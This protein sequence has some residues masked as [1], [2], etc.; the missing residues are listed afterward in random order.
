MGRSLVPANWR[1]CK[2]LRARPVFLPVHRGR[3]V[4]P[5]RGADRGPQQGRYD[6]GTGC[7]G[8]GDDADR[9]CTAGERGRTMPST[10][11]PERFAKATGTKLRI[12]FEPGKPAPAHRRRPAKLHS[13]RS[14]RT[15]HGGKSLPGRSCSNVPKPTRRLPLTDRA[16]EP[17]CHKAAGPCLVRVPEP[18]DPGLARQEPRPLGRS[19]ASLPT[20]LRAVTLSPRLYSLFFLG[21]CYCCC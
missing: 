7:G 6:A 20:A 5:C 12:S 9:H 17:L 2:P 3:R 4:S 8:H 21:W 10:R 11:T 18:P 16:A 19:P 15:T 14:A 1:E 13:S